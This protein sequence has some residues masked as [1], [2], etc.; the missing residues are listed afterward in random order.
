MFVGRAAIFSRRRITRRPRSPRRACPFSRGKVKASRNTGGAPTRQF[1]F[2]AVKARSS[3]SMM[4]AMLRSSS[5]R[6]IELEEGSDWAKS[7]SASKEEQCIKDLLL[8]VQRDNPFRWHEL[9]KEWRG[10]S[11]ETTTGVHRL[12]KMQR[13][14]IKLLVPAINVNDS[15][16]KSKF[17]NLY[18]CRA[19]AR[20]RLQSRTRRHDRRQSCRHLRL[21]RRRQRLRAIAARPGCARHHHRNRSDQRAPSGDGRFRS[22]DDRRHARPRR[23]LRHDHGQRRRHHARAHG[24]DEGPGDRLQHR[25][26]R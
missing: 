3:W 20:R 9:V 12:Y 8:E 17:D 11:E 22:Y 25:P 2:Q 18:G 15:V 7:A 6:V 16:T 4:A 5:T 24:A 21:W 19:L 23:H 1:R 13:S 14:R 26:F 10:V